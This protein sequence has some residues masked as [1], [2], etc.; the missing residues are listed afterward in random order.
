[1]SENIRKRKEVSSRWT[2]VRIERSKPKV[3]PS[4]SFQTAAENYLRSCSE[5]QHTSPT[6]YLADM[7]VNE[8]TLDDLNQ[9]VAAREKLVD[10]ETIGLEL[11]FISAVFKH[12]SE[13]T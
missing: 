9:F 12:N 1:M 2:V 11:E 3:K 8:I 10:R 4:V 5:P 6:Q 13:R 7:P